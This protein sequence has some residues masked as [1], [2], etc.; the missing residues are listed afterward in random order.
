M[1]KRKPCKTDKGED[2]PVPV[3]DYKE[4]GYEPEAVVNWLTNIGWRFG[5]DREFFTVEETLERFSFERVNASAAQIPYSKLYD[6]NGQHIRAK[7]DEELVE[8]TLPMLR[9]AYGDIDRA[10]LL[11]IMPHVKERLN[12]KK[13]I[14]DLT[15]FLFTDDFKL[16]E[17]SDIIFK[18]M[19]E[20]STKMVLERSYDVL[21]GLD[22]FSAA[23]QEEH[24]RTLVDE[25]EM[26]VGQVFSPLRWAVIAQRVSPPLFESMEVLG[27]A[28]SMR[29]LQQTI[30]LF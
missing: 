8:E 13:D 20:A 5:D 11:A 27:K 30:A 6:L 16:A 10:T 22:D 26:K 17:K 12:P 18:K 4:W 7:S 15:W 25:L 28:E 29:R 21:N 2:I 1:S 24:M 14:V 3:S 23:N 9:D 19:D